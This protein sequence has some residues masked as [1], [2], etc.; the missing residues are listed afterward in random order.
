MTSL[1]KISLVVA[2]LMMSAT[3]LAGDEKGPRTGYFRSHTTPLELLGE[4]GAQ[5]VAE[6]F[7]AEE[8]LSWQLDVPG[9]YDPQNPPGV[10]VFIN[11]GN[12]GGG[13]KVWNSVLQ[14]KNLIW[15]GAIDAGD[16]APMNE[17]MLKAILASTLI[18]KHYKVNP[19]RVYVAGF[20]GGSQVANILATSRPELFRGG[21]FMSGAVFWGERVPSKIEM[22]QKNRFVFIAGANDIA[23]VKV[24]RTAESYRDAGV[25]NTE[26][27]VVAN[28]R[29]KL[30]GPSVFAKAIDYLDSRN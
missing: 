2:L 20:S 3:G 23:R 4:R 29:Q 6:V 5:A 10:I 8:K 17:R 12:W 26:L 19:E 15:I 14:E 27:I 24:S 28:M 21:L 7:A 22:V 9:N 30:P 16:K 1:K 13:K 11:R 18:A 25:E